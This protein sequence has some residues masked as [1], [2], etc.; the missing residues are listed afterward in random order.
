MTGPLR[1]CGR[2]DCKLCR[3]NDEQ[4]QDS[5]HPDD[6]LDLAEALVGIAAIV[7]LAVVF[8]VLIP[9]LS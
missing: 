9:V 4:Y 5:G 6:R 1:N 8:F 2:P 7:L 3:W